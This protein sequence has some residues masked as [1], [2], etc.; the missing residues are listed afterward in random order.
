MGK[1][2]KSCWACSHCPLKPEVGCCDLIEL[3]DRGLRTLYY[4]ALFTSVVI[5]RWAKKLESFMLHAGRLRDIT[6]LTN[7]YRDYQALY[8]WDEE[9]GILDHERQQVCAK[10]LECL[11]KFVSLVASIL[12]P[13]PIFGEWG[14]INSDERISR[15]ARSINAC[16]HALALA[17]AVADRAYVSCEET[18]LAVTDNVSEFA[19]MCMEGLEESTP[20]G[21]Q[22]I[23]GT[24]TGAWGMFKTVREDAGS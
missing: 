24:T 2:Q 8:L 3:T 15:L 20:K 6:E 11:G 19:Y 9:E 7:C 1:C 16:G 14:W 21:W 4:A 18:S 5:P 12:T 10:Q 22:G 23:I 13:L 17:G